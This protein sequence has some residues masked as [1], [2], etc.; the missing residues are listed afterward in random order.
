M[1][2]EKFELKLKFKNGGK[3]HFFVG[4]FRLFTEKTVQLEKMSRRNC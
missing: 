1:S 2:N 4:F 3:S